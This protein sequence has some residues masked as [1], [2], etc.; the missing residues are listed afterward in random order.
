[1]NG[2]AEQ[3]KGLAYAS[4][5][6][7]ATLWGIN[8]LWN[9]K[10]LAGG[11]SPMGIVALRNLG[12]MALLS[13]IFAVRDRSIFRVRK[14]HLKYLFGA[15]VFGVALFSCFCFTCQK[16][17]SL[18]VASVL[19]YTAPVFVLLLSAVLWRE[20]VTRKKL[21]ALGLT[22]SGCMLVCGLFDGGQNATPFGILMG[23]GA[24][25][26]YSLYSIFGRYATA[27]YQPI[28]VTVWTFIFAGPASLLLLRPADIKLVIASPQI[29][30]LA[31]FAM[32]V[33]T[34][35]PYLFY[36]WGLARVDP[37]RASII[38]AFEPVVA[39]LTGVWAFGE[40]MSAFGIVGI[41]CVLAGICIL[42]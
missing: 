8:G 20:P 17:C 33:S 37:G 23:V 14:E 9:R 28:K 4:I 42:R 6:A 22:L 18:A 25:F 39:S 1:M 16:L 21:L 5:L 35:L 29:I 7:A 31:M 10:L 36:T 2:P 30:L 32:I 15:G 26:F 12:A 38:A 40:T 3:K 11:L 19:L 13:V 27:H 41:V 24:G 34:V